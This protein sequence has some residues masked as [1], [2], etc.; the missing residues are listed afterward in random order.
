MNDAQICV[1]CRLNATK[2]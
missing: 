2:H 1:V